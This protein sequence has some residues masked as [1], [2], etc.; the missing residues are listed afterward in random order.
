MYNCNK[1]LFINLFIFI[2]YSSVDQLFIIINFYE[3]YSAFSITD[4]RGSSYFLR[5]PGMRCRV[6]M[7]YYIIYM[8]IYDY[9]TCTYELR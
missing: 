7:V 3:R 1:T 6:E 9:Q 4:A 2:V 8:I 5:N